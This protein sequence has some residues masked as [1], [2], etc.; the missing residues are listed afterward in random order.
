MNTVDSFTLHSDHG[1]EVLAKD[2]I[3]WSFN[4]TPWRTFKTTK[5]S[6]I[7]NGLPMSIPKKDDFWCELPDASGFICF[8]ALQIPDN[9]ILR[10]AYG[11]EVNRLQVPWHL[12]NS[13]NPES[14]LAPTTF[15]NVSAPYINP[16][17][18]EP[19]RF[20]VT[21]WVEHAGDYYFELDWRTGKFLWAKP[22]HS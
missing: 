4:Q 1:E 22:I 6:W 3:A 2:L 13:K 20:G 14:A 16:A 12:T 17:N 19:G 11:N 18:A 21:A 9:C 15:I 10:D 5:Y 8:E 7:V